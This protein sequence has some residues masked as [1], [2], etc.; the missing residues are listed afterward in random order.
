M[1]LINH[2]GHFPMGIGAA[3]LSSLVV[4]LDDVPGI[5][6]DELSSAIFHAPN[7]QLLMLSNSVIMSLV[8][9]AALD[10]PGGGVTA[11][12][13][14]APSLVRVL[15]RDLAGK[16]SWDSSILYSQPL[17]EDDMPIAFTK[18]GITISYSLI[19]QFYYIK[20]FALIIIVNISS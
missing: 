2:L 3:R 19:S 16:A 14:T 4:E 1:H 15:L 8:E 20:Y 9:L 18:H 13:T 5:D 11:G 10:A 17:V 7:I 12:L 6:G